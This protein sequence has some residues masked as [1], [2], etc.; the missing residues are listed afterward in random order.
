LALGANI[1]TSQRDSTLGGRERGRAAI[2][3]PYFCSFSPIAIK[4]IVTSRQVPDTVFLPLP[5]CKKQCMTSLE[6]AP[7]PSSD[8]KRLEKKN[9]VCGRPCAAEEGLPRKYVS[10]ETSPRP[11][12]DSLGSFCRNRKVLLSYMLPRSVLR[13]ILTRTRPAPPP[14]LYSLRD[15]NPRCQSHSKENILGGTL[16][17]GEWLLLWCS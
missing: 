15:G 2:S 13:R 3:L 16:S 12:P 8:P 6:L 1:Y 10:W 4:A 17:L 7:R 11:D 5:A 9:R 14:Q